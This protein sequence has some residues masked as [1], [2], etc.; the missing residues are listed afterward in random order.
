MIFTFSN[1]NKMTSSTLGEFQDGFFLSE[2]NPC[3]NVDQ[4]DIE[5][6]AMRLIRRPE[7]ERRRRLHFRSTTYLWS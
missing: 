6:V 2:T 3:A 1:G 7:V 5:D 4:R